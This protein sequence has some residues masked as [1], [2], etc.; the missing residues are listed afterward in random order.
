[1]P[2]YCSSFL[3]GETRQTIGLRNFSFPTGN[4][5]SNAST[6]GRTMTDRPASLKQ[7]DGFLRALLPIVGYCMGNA[8]VRNWISWEEYLWENWVTEDTFV[9]KKKKEK[10]N[11]WNWHFVTLVNQRYCIYIT[12]RQLRYS[13]LC[14]FYSLE[15]NCNYRNSI[16]RG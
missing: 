6:L 14:N 10:K 1:M 11:V 4:L 7:D 9:K 5:F 8:I 13:F 15:G 2:L 12:A 16:V 3:H